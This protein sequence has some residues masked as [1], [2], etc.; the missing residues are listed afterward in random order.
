M[1]GTLDGLDD[2]PAGGWSARGRSR[3]L[4]AGFRLDGVTAS[5]GSLEAHGDG[6]L[7]TTSGLVGTDLQLHAEDADLSHAMH[8]FGVDDFPQV[9]VRVDG[10]LRVKTGG[11]RLD[12]ATGKAGDIEV[13]VDGLIAGTPGL[14]GT[15][16]HVSVHGPRLASLGPYF[17]QPG[18]PP[19]PFS[20]TG[21][22][23][24]EGDACNLTDVIAE[25]EHTRV[26]VNGTVMMIERLLGTDIHIESSAPDLRNSGR[27]L[28]D[29]TTLPDL[30]PKPFTLTTRLHVVESG[31]EI[32]GLRASLDR[33]KATIDGR[34]GDLPSLVGTD[35]TIEGD[36]PDASLFN[37]LA[38]VTVPVAPFTISG[39]LQRT[40]TAFVF[41]RVSARLA[42]HSVD[43]HGS[44]GE[45][46]HRIGT[47]LD[48]QASGPGTGLIADLTGFDEL[49]DKPFAIGGHFH[50][51]PE[52]FTAEDLEITLGGSDLKGALEVDIRGKPH[53][54]ARVSSKHVEID[55]LAPRP[56]GRDDQAPAQQTAPGNSKTGLVFSEEPIDFGWLRRANAD[57]DI[58]VG[59]LQ[60]PVERFHD[61]ELEAHLVDGRLD[62]NRIAMAGSREGSGSGSLVLEPVGDGY[63]GELDLDLSALRFDPPGERAREA[64]SPPPIDFNV[65]LRAQGTSPHEFAGTSNGSI[66]IIGG[67]GVMDSR[68]LDMI[69]A[70]ILLTL[71]QAFNPF[72]KDD[73][74]AELQCAVALVTFEDGIA[75]LEPMAV[76]SDKMTM[77]GGGKVDLTTE[78]LKFD[79]ITKPRK[80]IGLSTS[81]LTN[82]YIEVGGTLGKPVIELKPIEAAASTGVAVATMGISLVAKG[83]LD[84]VTAEKK[85]CK[86]A[87]EEIEEIRQ[88]N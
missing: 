47:D 82:P 73:V 88:Q 66:Q 39:R 74:A 10:R 19:A 57:V 43:L 45:K 32:D 33:A 13:A 41:D 18:L 62:I 69:T 50:G 23:H 37:A 84:R 22:V 55:T 29:L 49:P 7:S 42:G 46:P 54:T 24:I 65:R 60:L 86:K 77:L 83:M 27:L 44:L 68:V 30:P 25:V 48:L 59:T 17:Q 6:R 9:P 53:I 87:L 58:T 72:A 75:T 12:G 40:D 2:L 15:S 71:L 85:V 63:R 70:D 4:D 5:V 11:F 79:W 64:A 20:I 36:G 21:D 26:A 52:K 67:R 81:M 76:Q 80:G 34:I 61:F 16:G 31:Y 3:I 28:A 51:T 1:C 78:K 38:G 35:L 8:I 56:T 14:D